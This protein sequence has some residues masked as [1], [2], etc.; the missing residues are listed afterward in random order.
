MRYI[1]DDQV[2]RHVTSSQII[3]AVEESFR[4]LERGEAA[5]FP[6]VRGQAAGASRQFGIKSGIDGSGIVGVKVGSHDPAARS[7]GRP[8]H[9]ATTL[10]LDER[11][12]APIAVVEA[13]YLN[14]LRTAAANAVA[15]RQLARK[16]ARVLGVIGIGGQAV[17][18]VEA[19]VATCE[20]ERLLASS[21][22]PA[23]DEQFAGQ[24]R[25]RVD[26]PVCFLSAEEVVRHADIVVTATPSRAPVLETRWVRPGT[27]IS[28]MGADNVGKMELPIDL[29]AASRLIVDHPVQAAVIGEVQHAVKAG[30]VSIEQLQ[31]CGLGT[32][33]AGKIEG[34]LND[35]QITIFDSSGVAVQDVFAARAALEIVEKATMPV[36]A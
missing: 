15:T 11:R 3:A 8:A 25:K 4:A 27:H 21:R 32:L 22:G 36:D 1:T 19:I 30:L 13:N 2:R 7:A 26:M 18:E 16:N 24:I 10:L 14:G 5:V 31:E 23:S 20:I 34:R 33:L 12:L 29:V 35:D 17:F 28:A 9:S 6:V